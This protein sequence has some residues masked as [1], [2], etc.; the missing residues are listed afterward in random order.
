MCR[1]VSD[2]PDAFSCVAFRNQ[3]STLAQLQITSA[4]HF[5]Y[6]CERAIT[7]QGD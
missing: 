6:R 2:A 1:M 3:R 4:F 5:N 7:P